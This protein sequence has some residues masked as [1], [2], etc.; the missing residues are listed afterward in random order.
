MQGRGR[1]TWCFGMIPLAELGQGG[2]RED[3]GLER[4]LGGKEAGRLVLRLPACREQGSV[5]EAS[6]LSIA[7]PSSALSWP[8]AQPN[9]RGLLLCPGN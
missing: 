9:P 8:G 2:R 5:A 3:A 7:S 1:V 4:D 6:S